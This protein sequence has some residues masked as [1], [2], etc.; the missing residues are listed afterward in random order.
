MADQCLAHAPDRVAIIGHDGAPHP[1][2]FATLAAMTDALA[3]ALR[4][5]RGDRIGILRTQSSW[6]AAAHL[7]VWKSAAISVPLFK[8]FGP[9]ALDLRL[10]DAGISTVITDTQGRRM[11][12]PFPIC[13]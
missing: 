4:A 6:T 5:D 12:A 1:V 8:L 3:H 13:G 10:R 11:L 7:A 9:D 2:T